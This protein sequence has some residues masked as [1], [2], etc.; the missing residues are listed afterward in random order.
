[1]KPVYSRLRNLGYLNSGFIDDSLLC[2]KTIAECS[3]FQYREVCVSAQKENVFSWK[4]IIDSAQM[5]VYLPDNKVNMVEIEC[6]KNC[7]SWT[8]L[9]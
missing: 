5:L 3:D 6:K 4:N 2:D 7:I 8:K 1:M 9:Q